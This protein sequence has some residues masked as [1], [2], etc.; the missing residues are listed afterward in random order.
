M[1]CNVADEYTFGTDDGNPQLVRKSDGETIPVDPDNA[2]FCRL[3]NSPKE[4]ILPERFQLSRL[5][6]RFFCHEMKD[7]FIEFIRSS[8]KI[9]SVETKHT[10]LCLKSVT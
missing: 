2:D 5:A 3:L 1:G 8:G 9:L 6:F 10:F 7:E 4:T